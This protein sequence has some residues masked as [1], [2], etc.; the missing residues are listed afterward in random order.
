MDFL[1]A[2]RK[3]IVVIH[4]QRDAGVIECSFNKAV[5]FKI[6]SFSD[7]QIMNSKL[8]SWR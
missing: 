4:D 5:G 3:N 2:A 1:V 7:H 8:A 6:D